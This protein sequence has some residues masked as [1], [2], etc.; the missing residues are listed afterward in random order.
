MLRREA[1]IRSACVNHYLR[2][3]HLGMTSPL[4]FR[5]IEC[6]VAYL[7]LKKLYESD[8]AT[9][10][11]VLDSMGRANPDIFLYLLNKKSIFLNQSEVV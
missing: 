6:S 9:C 7:V 1:L 10:V 5:C 4:D 2:K 3:I 8:P 11:I